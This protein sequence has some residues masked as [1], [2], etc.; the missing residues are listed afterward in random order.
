[1]WFMNKIANPFVRL[2]LRSP[3]H[4]LMSAVVLLIT[5][6]GKKSGKEYTLPVQYVQDEKYIY[7]LPGMPE[8]KTW[9]RNLKGGAPVRIILGGKSLAGSGLLLRQDVDAEAITKGFALYLQRF[10]ALAKAHH[11]RLD[12]NGHFNSDDIHKASAAIQMIAVELES[13]SAA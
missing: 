11:V 8:Q 9:W 13:G 7:I 6:R 10:P 1:M 2:L 3:F 12:A 4:H 5:Y